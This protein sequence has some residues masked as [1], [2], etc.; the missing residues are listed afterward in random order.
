MCSYHHSKSHDTVDCKTHINRSQLPKICLNCDEYHFRKDCPKPKRTNIGKPQ[1]SDQTI[2]TIFSTYANIPIDMWQDINKKLEKLKLR[3][4]KITNY[5]RSTCA[6]SKPQNTTFN[7]QCKTVWFSKDT[8][9][10][11]TYRNPSWLERVNEIKE[12]LHDETEGKMID[13]DSSDVDLPSEDWDFW[14]CK[15][16][17]QEIM[18]IHINDKMTADVWVIIRNRTI[19]TLLDTGAS[20]SII[21]EKCIQCTDKVPPFAGIRFSFT[22]G[23][24]IIPIGTLT[25]CICLG[26]HKFKQNFIVCRNLKRLLILGLDF[27]HKFHIGTSGVSDRK[28]YL[29]KDR[30]PLGYSP[31]L[32]EV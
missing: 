19:Y 27:H 1:H 28:L 14:L 5:V 18:Q 6:T 23:S 24:N 7:S 29:H 8:S 26:T 25:L 20:K 13:T 9:K 16:P 21:S 30:N 12:K 15:I 2:H 17:P 22:S 31:Q 10:P 3:N 11:R 32:W 4:R